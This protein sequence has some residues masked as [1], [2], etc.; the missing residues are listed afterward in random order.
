MNKKK[1][2]QLGF[3]PPEFV[4]T[5]VIGERGQ[6]VIPK[7]V[8][9]SLNLTPGSKLVVLRHA[10]NGPIILIPIEHMQQVMEEMTKRFGIIQSALTK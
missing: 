9:D 1:S 2:E 3:S 8:R 4:G 6:L 10:N 7:S 5:T